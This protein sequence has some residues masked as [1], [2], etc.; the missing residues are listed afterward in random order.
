MNEFQTSE[1]VL[2]RGNA[3]RVG[4]MIGFLIGIFFGIWLMVNFYA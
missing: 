4:F 3:F 2:T 1:G